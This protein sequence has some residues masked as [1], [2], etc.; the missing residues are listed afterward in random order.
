MILKAFLSDCE[1]NTAVRTVQTRLCTLT[2][3]TTK[4]AIN[5]KLKNDNK[6]TDP[7]I[8]RRHRLQVVLKGLSPFNGRL[9]LVHFNQ[10][11]CGKRSKT[12]HT[13]KIHS[14]GTCF[15]KKTEFL[16]KI[17]IC[18]AIAADH[19]NFLKPLLNT[20]AQN[21]DSLS[22]PTAR[23]KMRWMHRSYPEAEEVRG[24]CR[25]LQTS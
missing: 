16:K 19:L 15:I 8:I 10:V 20:N 13:K 6:A 11:I 2:T 21:K 22:T 14:L 24:S 18:F 25:A 1:N 5:E 7:N 17:V 12:D 9:E 3:T 23:V 4:K